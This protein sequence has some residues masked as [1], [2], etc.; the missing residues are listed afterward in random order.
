MR[1]CERIIDVLYCRLL[2]AREA[3]ID[4]RHL[5]TDLYFALAALLPMMA[6]LVFAV[7]CITSGCVYA[8]P[9]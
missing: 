9:L 2:F 7:L 1:L 8:L 6:Q 5:L 3:L 4:A